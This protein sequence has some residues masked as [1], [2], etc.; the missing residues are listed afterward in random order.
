LIWIAVILVFGVSFMLIKK[1]E[2]WFTRTQDFFLSA[3]L[4]LTALFMLEPVFVSIQQ[5]LKP[6]PT[7]PISSIINQQNFLLMGGLLAL[8]LGGFVWQERSRS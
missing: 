3:G 1:W 7:I 2:G 6:I 8:A 4:L 5:N